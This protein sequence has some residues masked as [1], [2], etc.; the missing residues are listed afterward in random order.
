MGG[1]VLWINAIDEN[2]APRRINLAYGE[3]TAEGHSRNMPGAP[4]LD[5]SIRIWF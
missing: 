5:Y 2:I 3:L 4:R 1:V